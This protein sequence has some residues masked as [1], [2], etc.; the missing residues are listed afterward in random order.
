MKQV[1]NQIRQGWANLAASLPRVRPMFWPL[2]VLLLGGYLVDQASK[3]PWVAHRIAP[4]V[5]E[6]RLGLDWLQSPDSP[7]RVA[8]ERVLRSGDPGFAAVA[9]LLRA[10]SGERTRFV[11]KI[12]DSQAVV[13][14][15]RGMERMVVVHWNVG[16]TDD[17]S[18]DR[19]GK[20]LDDEFDAHVSRWKMLLLVAA[21]LVL[22]VDQRAQRQP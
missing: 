16:A 3:L 22:L 18:Y 8:G 6:A 14:T 15:E 7:S 4:H 21:V 9:S 13:P 19:L 20:Y 12:V 11:T 17:T 5:V 2:L 10:L 1:I